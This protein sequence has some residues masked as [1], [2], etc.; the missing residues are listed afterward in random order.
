MLLAEAV[1][2]TSM[3]PEA[4]VV[5]DAVVVVVVVVVAVVAFLDFQ[6]LVVPLGPLP[7]Q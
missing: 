2:A 1:P 6:N 5:A 3:A 7:L 4:A